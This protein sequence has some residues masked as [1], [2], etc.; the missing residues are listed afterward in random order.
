MGSRAKVKPG[1]LSVAGITERIFAGS[2]SEEGP[3]RRAPRAPIV[4][5][6]AGTTGKHHPDLQTQGPRVVFW[7]R[8][9]IHAVAT[10]L[11]SPDCSASAALVSAS[12]P[13]RIMALPALPSPS[14]HATR[15]PAARP[16]ANRRHPSSGP[17]S[18]HNAGGGSTPDRAGQPA[19]LACGPLCAVAA[20][21]AASLAA[22]STQP[23]WLP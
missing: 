20:A 10:R 7:D 18:R 8:W 9:P 17:A 11:V 1:R 3:S 6:A 4:D 13:S 19:H 14:T 23:G 15:H 5:A 22:H 21:V 2:A 16:P 12:A